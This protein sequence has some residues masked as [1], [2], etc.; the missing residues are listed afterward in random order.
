M[1]WRL[2]G[3]LLPAADDRLAHLLPDSHFP[4]PRPGCAVALR[5]L[6][7]VEELAP[8]AQDKIHPIGARVELTR[9]DELPISKVQGR[10]IYERAPFEAIGEHRRSLRPRVTALAT[11]YAIFG[12]PT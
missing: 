1:P 11:A 10:P 8:S 12:L 6:D 7:V 3:A 5:T 4:S 9:D 2:V